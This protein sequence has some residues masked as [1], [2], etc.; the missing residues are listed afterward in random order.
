[1]QV[2]HDTLHYFEISSRIDPGGSDKGLNLGSEAVG[3]QRRTLRLR[4]TWRGECV[5]VQPDG[6]VSHGLVGRIILK[7][8]VSLGCVSSA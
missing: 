2:L 3:A 6:L 1:M 5:Q 7:S 8:G 4:R